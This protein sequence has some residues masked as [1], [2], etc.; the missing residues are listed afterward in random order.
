MSEPKD[1]TN[2]IKRYKNKLKLPRLSTYA[3]HPL[4]KQDRQ[5]CQIKTNVSPNIIE[6]PNG[7]PVLT[8]ESIE[9]NMDIG[10]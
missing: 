1:S 3:M 9:V 2:S 4:Q 5:N 7:S 10:S 6:I 8:R